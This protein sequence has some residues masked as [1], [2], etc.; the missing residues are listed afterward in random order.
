[1]LKRRRNERKTKNYTMMYTLIALI[2][3]VFYATFAQ[4]LAHKL[5]T[6]LPGDSSGWWWPWPW[7]PDSSGKEDS[8]HHGGGSGP[9]HPGGGNDNTKEWDVGFVNAVKTSSKGSVYEVSAPTYEKLAARF[10]VVFVDP[11]DEITYTFT[12]KN[13]GSI[14]AKIQNIITTVSNGDNDVIEF[15]VRGINVGDVLKVGKTKDVVVTAS[16]KKGHYDEIPV[17]VKKT[18]NVAIEYVQK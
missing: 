16:F 4:P 11:G 3:T 17:G 14:D 8:S 6:I 12:I 18:L 9:Y 15:K 7:N 2:L 1:M 5:E 13:L 10:D